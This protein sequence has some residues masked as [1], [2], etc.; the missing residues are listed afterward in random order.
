MG[1][2]KQPRN[3]AHHILPTSSNLLGICF[4]IF[5]LVHL[6]DNAESSLLDEFSALAIVVF[7]VASICSYLSLRDEHNPILERIADVSFILGLCIL[8][9]TAL[10][11][12]LK[13]IQ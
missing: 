2:P 13:F 5:S 8:T 12:T 11:L 10:L 4:L 3:V 6:K 9:A 1:T 7:L